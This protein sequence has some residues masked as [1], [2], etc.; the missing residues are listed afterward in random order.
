MSEA[1]EIIEPL[2]KRG[3]IVGVGA[4]TAAIIVGALSWI[5]LSPLAF[6]L[7]K[8]D[9]AIRERLKAPATYKRIDAS[10]T[11]STSGTYSLTYEAEN[12][13]GVPLQGKGLCF[14]DRTG[15]QVSWLE[16]SR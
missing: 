14:I 8:C 5:Y 2:S 7:R 1:S 13:F 3:Q 15:Q 11:H 16:T 6:D 12:S 9:D 10:G 4:L